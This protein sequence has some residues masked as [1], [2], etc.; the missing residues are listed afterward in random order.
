MIDVVV[1]LLDGFDLGSREPCGS[2]H[3]T[4]LPALFS[5]PHPVD[6][7]LFEGGFL[8]QQQQRGLWRQSTPGLI[9]LVLQGVL[10]RGEEREGGR[11]GSPHIHI[12]DRRPSGNM[13]AGSRN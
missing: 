4:Y 11:V 10:P 5:S 1:H 3:P 6:T 2:Q 9:R 13:R 8:E 12:L 7:R